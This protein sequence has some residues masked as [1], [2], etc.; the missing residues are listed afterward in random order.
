MRVRV[1]VIWFVTILAGL[2]VLMLWFGRKKSAETAVVVSPATNSAP[3][4][5]AAI[6]PPLHSN[7]PVSQ[8][9]PRSPA[10]PPPPEN[11]E[12]QMRQGLAE[13]NNEDVV[14]YGRV[15]ATR[16]SPNSR[17]QFGTMIYTNTRIRSTVR[18]WSQHDSNDTK[19]C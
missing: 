12:Q 4:T 11:K 1:T 18:I 13:L 15:R 6:N 9:V 2:T 7:V 14:L 10:L 5:V 3:L 16:N 8:T 19:G 17:D